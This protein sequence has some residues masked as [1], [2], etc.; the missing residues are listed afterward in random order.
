MKVNTS[1]GNSTLD[2]SAIASPCGS[3]GN[4]LLSQLSPSSTILMNYSMVLMQFPSMSKALPG[5][6]TK[7][8]SLNEALIAQKSSGLILKMSTLSCG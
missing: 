1:W 2:P 5:M 7:A 8:T 6:E 4:Y 3:I